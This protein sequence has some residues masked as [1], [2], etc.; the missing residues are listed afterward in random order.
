MT[1]SEQNGTRGRIT[2]FRVLGLLAIVF[3]LLLLVLGIRMFA[4]GD[5]LPWLNMIQG[6]IG[7]GFGI[8][9][10]VA[11]RKGRAQTTQPDS[12]ATRSER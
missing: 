10:L 8:G 1:S 9:F 7:V 12:E 5:G 3:G 11:A 6:L 4:R 2:M